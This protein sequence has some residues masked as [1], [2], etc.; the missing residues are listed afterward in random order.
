MVSLYAVT[1]TPF[2][3]DLRILSVI[4]EKGRI[5][6]GGNEAPLLNAS[7]IE[8]MRPLRFQIQSLRYISRKAL[9]HVR[10]H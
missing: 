8:D 6:A 5:H 4:L 2:I 7:L 9:S 1:I 10:M 3:R